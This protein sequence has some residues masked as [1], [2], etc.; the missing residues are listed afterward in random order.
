MGRD[1]S[2]F[3]ALPSANA[4]APTQQNV[5]GQAVANQRAY[6]YSSAN[7]FDFAKQAAIGGNL[8]GT[9]VDPSGAIVPNAKVTT[10]GP[11]GTKTVTS[12]ADG[13]FSFNQLTP[14]QYSLQAAAPGFRTTELT[15]LAVLAGKPSDLKVKLDVGATSETVEVT[16]AAPAVATDRADEAKVDANKSVNAAV[17][18]TT[19][20][21]VI[22]SEKSKRAQLS[23]KKVAA[24][25]Q[26]A[27]GG[28]FGAGA[29]PDANSGPVAPVFQWTLSAEGAV[30]RSLDGGKTWQSL[31]LDQTVADRTTF[32]TLS[33]VGRD[34]WVGGKSGS[35]YHSPDSGQH[36]ARVVPQINGEKLN[37]DITRVDFSDLQNGT[38]STSNGQTWTTSDAGRTWERR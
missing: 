3:V 23:R 11:A 29:G 21:E 14:G 35:L 31:S 2:E 20:S 10:V 12:D 33:A 18:T 38:V 28:L 1:A 17:A 37:S 5:V 22:G 26:D 15:Q 9:I 13:K 34:I 30:Q 25:Q 8:G 24:A 19:E 36:W 4:P 7:A 16:A 32:R 6:S 27:I